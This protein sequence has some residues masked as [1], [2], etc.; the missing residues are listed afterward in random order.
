MSTSVEKMCMGPNFTPTLTNILVTRPI[1][2]GQSIQNRCHAGLPDPRFELP[3][4]KRHW[5]DQNTRIKRFRHQ[6]LHDAFRRD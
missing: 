6:Q 1:P 4:R 5:P 3:L 2:R